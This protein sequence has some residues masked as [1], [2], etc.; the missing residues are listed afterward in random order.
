[1]GAWVKSQLGTAI[2]LVAMFAAAVAGY[3]RLETRQ[4]AIAAQLNRKADASTIVRELDAIQT[5]LGRIEDKVD[6][7]ISQ[8][9]GPSNGH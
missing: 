1:M 5:T 9:W 8:D 3:S 6:S 4:E 7:H 2:P